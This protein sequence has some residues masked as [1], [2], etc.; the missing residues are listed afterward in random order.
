MCLVVE[1][2]RIQKL[3]DVEYLAVQAGLEL[4]RGLNILNVHHINKELTHPLEHFAS[5]SLPAAA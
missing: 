4:S 3:A 1:M 5:P 2:V